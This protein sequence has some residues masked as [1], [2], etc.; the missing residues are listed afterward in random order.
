MSMKSLADFENMEFNEIDGE[1]P[2]LHWLEVYLID[3]YSAYMIAGAIAVI[4]M[5]QLEIFKNISA[6]EKNHFITTKLTSAMTKM[7]IVQFTNMGFL[8]I[9]LNAKIEDLHLPDWFPL[10]KGNYKKFDPQ[11]FRVVGSTI[12]MTMLI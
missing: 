8:M 3:R 4:N 10:L 7:A 12:G 2:C 11:W 9:L 5:I 6:I 1:N